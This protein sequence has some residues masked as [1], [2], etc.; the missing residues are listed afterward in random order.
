MVNFFNFRTGYRVMAVA[1]LMTVFFSLNGESFVSIHGYPQEKPEV[2]DY[3]FQTQTTMI[4]N[5]TIDRILYPVIGFPAMVTAVDPEMSFIIRSENIPEIDHVRIIREIGD[6]VKEF[7]DLIPYSV[8]QCGFGLYKVK[9]IVPVILPS[10]RYDLSVKLKGEEMPIISRSSVFFPE[11]DAST[12]FFIW[13]D[14]QIEDLQSKMAGDLN[15]N[16][17]EYPYKSDSILD[18]SRQAGIIKTTISNLNM[19]DRHFVTML[20]DIVFGINYQ[21]EYEDIPSLIVNLEIPFFPVPGNHDGYAKFTEQNNLFSPLDWDGLQYWT[22][23]VGPLHYAFNFNGQTFLMLNTY[24]GTPQR[25]AAGDALGIGDNAAVP[26]SNWGGFLT[27]RSLAW[28]EI[29]MDDYDVFGLFSHMTPLGQNA[30]GKYH[31]M[32]KFPKDSVIGVTDSQEWNIETSEYDSDPTDLIFN[33][34]EKINTG[35]KLAELITRQ[36]PPPIYFS[37]HTHKDRLYLFEKDSELVDGSGVYA[38][39]DMEFIMT[40]TAA[41]SGQLYWGFRKVDVGVTGDVSYNYTCER[42]VNCMPGSETEKGFQSVPAGNMWVTYKWNSFGNETESIFAGGDGSADSVSAEVMNYLPTEEPVTLRFFMPAGKSYKIE[43]PKFHIS[44]AAVSKDMTTL[45]LTVKGSIA[46]G[47]EMDKFLAKDFSRKVE[48]VTVTPSTATVVE[49]QI[50]SPASIFEDEPLSAEV[51]NGDEFLSL[52]WIRNKIEFAQ[53]KSFSVKFDNYQ[54]VETI[55]LIYI[56]KSG[57]HGTALFKTDIQKRPEEEP[58]E[59]VSEEIE[60]IS[61][62]DMIE[63]DEIQEDSDEDSDTQEAKKKKSGCSVT[64][65]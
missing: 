42:G 23:F 48:F 19:G 34:T 55:F 49:P 2:P 7:Q 20:G 24:D 58:D 10:V 63:I 40:T 35:I 57:V 36:F 22:K 65:I 53:G 38:K 62:P 27:D 29:M 12:K 50:D 17:G 54:N 4:I 18:F 37:G 25:R 21:R 33:E 14:P 45:I 41:T 46:A 64:V 51:K 28:I 3:Q 31:K 59:E 8:E 60:E 15:Y 16:S 13:A 5:Q 39:D 61:D 47:S 56:D 52:V 30:T 44:N 32:K 6:N 9:M 26:V 43:N 11:F 1:V